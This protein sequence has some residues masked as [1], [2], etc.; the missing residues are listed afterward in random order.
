M[1]EVKLLNNNNDT[2]KLFGP[3]NLNT[4]TLYVYKF[5]FVLQ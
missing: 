4:Y 2:L 3:D 5:D 1:F